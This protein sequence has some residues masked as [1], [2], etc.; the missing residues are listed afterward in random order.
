MNTEHF[1]AAYRHLV[2]GIFSKRMP[3]E[4]F[5]NAA[6]MINAE[7][8]DEAIVKELFAELSIG[9]PSKIDIH[10][11]SVREMYWSKYKEKNKLSGER[12]E[13]L[14]C[15]RN[16]CDGFGM[17]HAIMPKGT[18]L[19]GDGLPAMTT[20]REYDI[21]FRC[22]CILGQQYEKN[23][24]KPEVMTRMSEDKIS[25]GYWIKKETIYNDE[26]HRERNREKYAEEERQKQYEREMKNLAD[27]KLF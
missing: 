1:I 12:S 5:S 10:A 14:P 25:K 17:I 27:R 20:G 16:T 13:A 23:G 15:K 26:V 22:D 6:K 19:E 4:Y 2:N 8:M 18:R 3:D 24:N 9:N 11:N 7:R 21:M